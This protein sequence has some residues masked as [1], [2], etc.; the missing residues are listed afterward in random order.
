MSSRGETF[1]S[2]AFSKTSLKSAQSREVSVGSG[3]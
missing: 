1:A 2:E 3:I